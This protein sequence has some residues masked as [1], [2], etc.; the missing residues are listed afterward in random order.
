MVCYG[1]SRRHTPGVPQVVVN[2]LNLLSSM[3]LESYHK[4]RQH[5]SAPAQTGF[6]TS[7]SQTHPEISNTQLGIVRLAPEQQV[8]RLEISV[9]DTF[10][11][12]VFDGARD[13]PHDLSSVT[14][15]MTV[16]PLAIDRQDHHHTESL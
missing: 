7:T 6:E 8:L 11:M 4:A 10:V 13:S 1:P 5:Q 3:I 12:Q 16:F 14:V 2:T 9:D 15:Q